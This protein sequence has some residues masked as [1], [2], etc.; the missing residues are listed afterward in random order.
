MY[1]YMQATC[2]AR[3]LGSTWT[4]PDIRNAQLMFLF[5]TYQKIYLTLKRSVDS[6]EVYVD[7]GAYRDTL[8]YSLKT[9]SQHLQSL[10][11]QTLQTVD[12]L[13]DTK[14]RRAVFA[15]AWQNAYQVNTSKFGLADIT[16]YPAGYLSD[17]LLTRSSYPQ[18]DLRLID[19]HCLVSVCG[20]LHKT[21]SLTGASFVIDAMNTVRRSGVSTV[22]PGILSFLDVGALEKVDILETDIT[23]L[24]AGAAL[25]T[26][27][28]IQTK[29]AYTNKSFILSLFGY[30]V[31]CEKSVFWQL[32]DNKFCLDMNKLRFIEKF[33]RAR[34]YLDFTDL[35]LTTQANNKDAVS[36]AELQSDAVIKKLLTH[37]NSFLCVVDTPNLT[38]VI[39]D[40]HQFLTPGCFSVESQRPS[41]LLLADNGRVAEY[42]VSP[43][44]ERY[45]VTV[46]DDYLRNFI[47]DSAPT[48]QNTMITPDAVPSNK[49]QRRDGYICELLSWR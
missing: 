17:L 43:E 16:N 7:L 15:T 26:K 25:N 23:P 40:I 44:G 12:K 47:F 46:S 34:A 24:D 49:T 3:K 20:F 32:S 37:P 18:T 48:S 35:G 11:S 39:S 5:S 4:N 1:E 14:L 28:C 21:K 2:L 9:L 33:M 30:P 38:P 19:S 6:A 36:L 41:F 45:S 22:N 29:K 31:F 42:W 13:P 8:C 10:G 27:L